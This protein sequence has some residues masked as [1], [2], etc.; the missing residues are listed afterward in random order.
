MGGNLQAKMNMRRRNS[1]KK[2]L[3]PTV[4]RLQGLRLRAE[5]PVFHLRAVVR[6]QGL[7]LRAERPVFHL[8]AVVR[9][10]GLHLRAER[11]VVNLRAVV[12]L[13]GLRQARYGGASVFHLRAVVRY[14]ASTTGGASRIPPPRSGRLQ[15]LH[16]GRSVQ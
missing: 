16:Y 12:R 13:Q 3:R 2:T 1:L 15:G 6:L 9:L 14:K 10:Q 4:V 11:P 5:R 7:H 8:R